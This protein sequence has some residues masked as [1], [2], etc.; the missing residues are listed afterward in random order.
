MAKQKK[1]IEPAPQPIPQHRNFVIP[2][3]TVR[4]H[5]HEEDGI[6]IEECVGIVF[7]IAGANPGAKVHFQVEV[8]P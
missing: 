1:G 3:C 5:S 6:P 7:A 4:V 2:N 8:L